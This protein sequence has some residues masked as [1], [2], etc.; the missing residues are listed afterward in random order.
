[1]ILTGSNIQ[2]LIRNIR[3]SIFLRDC[4]PGYMIIIEKDT[5]QEILYMSEKKSFKLLLS[6]FLTASLTGCSSSSGSG[7]AARSEKEE[8]PSQETEPSPASEISPRDQVY[9]VGDT[10]TADDF[11]FTVTDAGLA[12]AVSGTPDDSFLTKADSGAVP[13]GEDFRFVYYTVDYQYTGS[14]ADEDV[15]TFLPEEAK[16]GNITFLPNAMAAFRKTGDAW[17]ISGVVQDPLLIS[18][19]NSS[20][21]ERQE[22]Y[23]YQPSDQKYQA[24]GIIS[25]KKDMLNDGPVT[26]KIKKYNIEISE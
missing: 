22:E 26:I 17:I 7:S 20:G 14:F 10:I 23:E 21:C 12:D 13:A 25:V 24:R 18:I 2:N 4:L 9:H 11:V 1:M 8:K 15:W 6:V 3:E 19:A 5:E 16:A